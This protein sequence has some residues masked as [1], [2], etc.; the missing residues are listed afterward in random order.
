MHRYFYM[1]ESMTQEEMNANK[2]RFVGYC[3]EYAG[4]REGLDRLLAYLEETDFYQAPS[5]TNYHL[6][7]PGGLCKHSINVFETAKALYEHAIEPRRAASEAAF[8]EPVP[9]ESIAVA[10]LF[11]D[12]CKVKMYRTAER[13]KKDEHGR[14]QSYLGYEVHDEFP[15]GHGEKS[16]FVLERFLRLKGCELL[17]IRWHMGLFDASE[18]G[19]SGRF[20]LR[21]AMESEPLVTIVQAADLL[22]ANCLEVTT[23]Y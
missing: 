11:H 3:K 20:S 18:Q 12:L 4:E 14:W 13:W 17:A 9:M 5:S 16:C 15:F 10:T 8:S 21:A 22:A 23:K 2:E 6:N 7:E 1:H 19:A